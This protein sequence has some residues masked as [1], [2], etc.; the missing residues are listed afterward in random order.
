MPETS[1]SEAQISW[2]MAKVTQITAAAANGGPTHNIA[3]ITHREAVHNAKQISDRDKRDWEDIGQYH[4]ATRTIETTQMS[5]A[6]RE[7]VTGV[8]HNAAVEGTF[9]KTQIDA[10]KRASHHPWNMW[11]HHNPTPETLE[12]RR[13]DRNALR[14]WWINKSSHHWTAHRHSGTPIGHPNGPLT[15]NDENRRTIATAA[16]IYG[17]D[18]LLATEG[19]EQ[20]APYRLIADGEDFDPSV[21]NYTMIRKAVLAVKM[22]DRLIDC[23]LRYQEDH[24]YPPDGSQ[25]PQDDDTARSM[26]AVWSNHHTPIMTWI[27]NERA[28]KNNANPGWD[29]ESREK[30][31]KLYKAI[32]RGA[33]E[34]LRQ[35]LTSWLP[36]TCVD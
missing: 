34:H 27:K 26:T 24:T 5:R 1:S 3:L 18:K 8:R 19:R 10:R 31:E 23:V 12:Y 22:Y 4:D 2:L 25:W 21:K 36:I 15:I 14:V 30:A 20:S 28:T 6:S 13:T 33:N 16:I 35:C 29:C 17:H 11:T 9:K 7:T 32:H